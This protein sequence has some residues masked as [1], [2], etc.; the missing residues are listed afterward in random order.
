MVKKLG[1]NEVGFSLCRT[2][3]GKLV[4]GP[5]ATGSPTSVQIPVSCP[6]SARFDSLYHCLAPT[7][8][9]F[10]PGYG[11]LRA[12]DAYQYWLPNAEKHRA[13]KLLT[14][15]TSHGG[16]ITVTPN[17]PFLTEDGWKWADLL[18]V[19]DKLFLET[20]LADAYV[21]APAMTLAVPSYKPRWARLRPALPLDMTPELGLFVGLI[22]ADGYIRSGKHGWGVTFTNMD[23]DLIEQICDLGNDLFG[24]DAKRYISRGNGAHQVFW[25]STILAHWLIDDLGFQK[26]RVPPCIWRSDEEVRTAFLDGVVLGDGS[27]SPSNPN[28]PNNFVVAVSTG[29]EYET[30]VSFAYLAATLGKKPRL[31]TMPQNWP[32]RTRD[33]MYQVVYQSERKPAQVPALRDGAVLR[34]ATSGRFLPG[35]QAGFQFTG[36]RTNGDEIKV[37][38]IEEQHGDFT[39]YDFHTET[40][41]LYAGS[42]PMITHNTHPGG[43]AFP[44]RTDIQSAI[45]T[46]A[47]NLCI[48]SDT[49]LK[50]FR[51]LLARRR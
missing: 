47:K 18:S 1:R 40:Q 20:R 3:Q 38:G 21:P 36:G 46:G 44:S 4:A 28:K 43:V 7:E 5:M 51:V 22:W 25:S 42:I 14:I 17:H 39:V 26:R 19:N 37:V 33:H 11:P 30:A 15:R 10:T 48:Q 35:T 2:A 16:S 41:V 50:C 13:E 45:Q 29:V 9:V 6:T 8:Y 24:L 23:G 12:E 32:S 49:A 34:D 31:R 27:I